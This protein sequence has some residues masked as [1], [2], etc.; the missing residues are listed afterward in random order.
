[1]NS[2]NS[3]VDI[4]GVQFDLDYDNNY[5]ALTE[6]QIT[7]LVNSADVYSKIIEPGKARVIMFSMQGDRIMSANDDLSSVIN[8]SLFI[9]SPLWIFQQ[10]LLIMGGYIYFYN[11]YNHYC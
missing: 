10:N 11:D 8:K 6:G 4:Y 2:I 3:D 7:S 5:L 1:M 9:V